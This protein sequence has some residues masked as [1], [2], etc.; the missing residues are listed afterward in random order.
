M[1]PFVNTIKIIQHNVQHWSSRRFDLI[2]NYMQESPDIVLINSHGLPNHQNIKIPGYTC[3]QQNRSG[4][5]HAGVAIAVKNRLQHKL[6][7]DFQY[8]D[9]VS[10]KLMTTL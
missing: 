5:L 4:E 8:S 2:N 6:Y 7:D 9:T 10:I 3:Y 1:T